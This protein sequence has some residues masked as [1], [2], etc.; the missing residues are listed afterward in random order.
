[1]R[2]PRSAR[3]NTGS[4][5]ESSGP[6]AFGCADP[7]FSA[8]PEQVDFDASSSSGLRPYH[9]HLAIPSS[10]QRTESL[11]IA[12]H[13]KLRQERGTAGAPP[14]SDVRGADGE[15]KTSGLIGGPNPGGFWRQI[16]NHGVK[17]SLVDGGKFGVEV[18]VAHVRDQ[19]MHPGVSNRLKRNH[20]D[21]HHLSL[22]PH[23]L[24]Q[25]LKKST[26][27]RAQV[28]NLGA[29]ARQAKSINDLLELESGTCAQTPS[30]GFPEEM[31]FR[32]V[33]L[34]HRTWAHYH[35]TMPLDS[36]AG[37]YNGFAQHQSR[38]WPIGTCRRRSSGMLCQGCPAARRR[39]MADGSQRRASRRVLH[40]L[41]QRDGR[42]A[43]GDARAS[44]SGPGTGLLLAAR[45][46]VADPARGGRRVVRLRALSLPRAARATER[47]AQSRRAARV[48]GDL[49]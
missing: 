46:D 3:A 28:E 32:L 34:A 40:H 17:M 48:V 6:P 31:I 22:R 11:E 13:E 27:C 36:E 12:A 4:R 16:R 42:G 21:P 30:L 2:A 24:R 37:S 49:L 23:C 19:G 15:G 39:Q 20:V 41:R 9:L 25:H 5:W 29:S 7:L 8:Q 14:L 18:G 43:T 35:S 44:A 26:G 33:R 45:G 38:G 10:K 47:G 1:M